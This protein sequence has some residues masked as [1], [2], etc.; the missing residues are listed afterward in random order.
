MRYAKVTKF[1]FC[2][3]HNA[4]NSHSPSFLNVEVQRMRNEKCHHR[5]QFQRKSTSG[6]PS[7][8]HGNNLNA[9]V[10]EELAGKEALEDHVL[11]FLLLLTTSLKKVFTQGREIC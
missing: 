11:L 8:A 5:I 4:I 7:N 3:F 6:A 10:L 1:V 2:V 9:F